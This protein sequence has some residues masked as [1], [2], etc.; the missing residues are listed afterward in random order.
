MVIAMPFKL[1]VI[2]AVVAG[3]LSGCAAYTDKREV[4]GYAD[5]M[6]GVAREQA[7]QKRGDASLAAKRAAQTVN[8]PFL[9]GKARPLARDVTL[10]APL[11]GAVDTVMLYKDAADL[12]TLAMRIQEATGIMVKVTPETLLPLEAFRPRLAEGATRDAGSSIASPVT[13]TLD[14][15][16]PLDSPL[17]IGGVRASGPDRQLAPSVP[18]STKRLRANG[19]Q[20]LP[21][22]LDSIALRLGVYWKYDSDLGALVFYRTETRAFEI[23]NADL[24][25]AGEMGVDL[26]G[27]VDSKGNSG[28]K[29]QSKSYLAVEEDEKGPMEAIVGRVQQFMTQAGQIAAGN[30]GL[31]VVTDTKTALDQIERFI[32]HENKMRSRRIELVFEEITVE[33]SQSAQAGVNWNVVFNSAGEGNGVNINGLSSLIEQEGAAL[34][35]GASVGS[36]QWAGSS[37]AVQALSRLGKVVDRKVNTFG[38]INGQPATTGRPERQKYISEL[39]QTQSYSEN[40]APTVSVTQEE[41]V[42]GRL[43][44]VLPYAYNNGDISL[45]VKYDNTPTPLFTKQ[46]LP[47]GSYVQSPTSVSDVLVRTAVVNS[48]Q[49]FVIS[50]FTQN[51]DTTNERRVDRKAPMIFGGSDVTDRIDRVTVL[52]LTAMVRE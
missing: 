27:G 49:P 33:Q 30:G 19:T 36:G 7:Q 6:T 21:A 9:A 52:V 22:V 47:D 34:S 17:P 44:T 1:T 31:L 37:V 35:L 42:S 25:I 8:R 20:P 41:E 39:E 46:S 51:R 40:S 18:V 28:I 48:G 23:K 45:A 29:S 43:L 13:A 15:L 12:P 3:A 16:V 5:T 24:V 38:T 11:R 4:G 32:E 10:P 26:S 14:T 2:A 50:A